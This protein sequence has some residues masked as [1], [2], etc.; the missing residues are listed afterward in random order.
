MREQLSQLSEEELAVVNAIEKEGSHVDD[1]IGWTGLAT[2]LV[3]RV[4]T[5]LC[6][7][8]YVKR[9]PGN[10]FTLNTGKK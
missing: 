1:I 7:K 8:K 5:V 4:L 10:I 3:L 9:N 6:I 2:A